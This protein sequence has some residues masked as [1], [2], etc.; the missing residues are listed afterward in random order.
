MMDGTGMMSM[1]VWMSLFGLLLIALLVLI[2][3]VIV[4]WLRGSE[5]LFS[6]KTRDNALEILRTRYARGEISRDELE[7]MKRDLEK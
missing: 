2:G 3:I 7:N 4:K 1:M 5:M 6:P